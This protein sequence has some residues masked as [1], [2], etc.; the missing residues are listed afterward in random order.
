MKNVE[1]VRAG[2]TGACVHIL[3]LRMTIKGERRLRDSVSQDSIRKEPGQA[4]S[5]PQIMQLPFSVSHEALF[6]LTLAYSAYDIMRI[7][8]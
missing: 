4:L 1:S 5:L 3:F 8:G 2:D 6:P 7:L